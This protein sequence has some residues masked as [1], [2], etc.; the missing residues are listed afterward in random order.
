MR[1]AA[2]WESH[3]P[4]RC[5]R[6]CRSWIGLRLA[7]G[8]RHRRT[9]L[10]DDLARWCGS[11]LSSVRWQ[12]SWR[13]RAP[14]HFGA[15]ASPSHQPAHDSYRRLSTLM[16]AHEK[17]VSTMSSYQLPNTEGWLDHLQN[18]RGG[19]CHRPPPHEGVLLPQPLLRATAPPDNLHIQKGRLAQTLATVNAYKQ[20]SLA[21]PRMGKLTCEV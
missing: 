12:I 19:P 2:P 1:G 8:M 14:S 10:R 17:L 18:R 3:D 15:P 20:T 16:G 5:G 13:G 21:P 4:L 7:A 11:L 9:G 6:S